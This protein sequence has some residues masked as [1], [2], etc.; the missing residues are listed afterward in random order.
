MDWIFVV[1][2]RTGRLIHLSHERYYNH[3]L[4]HPH[5]HDKL[6]LIKLTIKSPKIVRHYKDPQVRYFYDDDKVRSPSE[7]YLLVSVKYLNGEGYVI[8]SFFTNKV[9]GTP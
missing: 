9:T 4:H 2:D 3:I 5:M 6:E 8:T 1:K 7:R